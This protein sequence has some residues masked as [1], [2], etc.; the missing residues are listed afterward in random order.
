MSDDNVGVKGMRVSF[1][2]FQKM[3][4]GVP[5][6]LVEQPKPEDGPL[7]YVLDCVSI[8]ETRSGHLRVVFQETMYLTREVKIVAER[9]EHRASDLTFEGS[10]GAPG[11]G[12]SYACHCGEAMWSPN[13]AENA[14]P[15]KNLDPDEF[16]MSPEDCI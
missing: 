15:F 3:V 6:D 2:P 13:S 11:H 10:L 16:I 12:K 1:L 9:C 4:F 14:V 5:L 8:G 7:E